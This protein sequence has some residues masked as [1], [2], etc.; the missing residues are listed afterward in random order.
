MIISTSMNFLQV[1]SHCNSLWCFSKQY[2]NDKLYQNCTTS[3]TS[4]TTYG[5]SV[6]VFKTIHVKQIARQ[7]TLFTIRLQCLQFHKKC[8][9]WHTFSTQHINT[10]IELEISTSMQHRSTPCWMTPNSSIRMIPSRGCSPLP[11]NHEEGVHVDRNHAPQIFTS[12]L[13]LLILSF[14]F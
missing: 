4:F 7:T 1:L 14:I 3:L 9:Q 12:M 6:T 11:R 2:N 13:D 10:D 8:K 5:I